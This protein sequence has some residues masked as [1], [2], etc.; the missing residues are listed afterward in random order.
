MLFLFSA[1][2]AYGQINDN[3][4]FIQVSGIITDISN[5][6]V[7]GVAVISRNLHRASVSER[8]GI[9]SITSTPG[10]TIMYRSLGFKRYHTIIPKDY[11]ERQCNVDIVLEAD[12]IQIEAVNILPWKS[13]NEFIK[14]MTKANPVDPIVQNMND[15]IASI[16]V[17]IANQTNVSISPEAGFRY[18]ME[19]N[20]TNMATRNQYPV[21][22]LLNPFAWAKFINGVKNG[23]F[24]NQ[25]FNKPA[26][27]KIRKKIKKASSN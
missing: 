10:D 16:Y 15:N 2:V 7:Q 18:A 11:S 24:K 13:Y 9:Y 1:S 22:N 19:Q 26:K 21:N 3:E 27:A 8:T 4:R 23:L 5:R 20:F 25:K 14:D 17:A 6:P 12:T